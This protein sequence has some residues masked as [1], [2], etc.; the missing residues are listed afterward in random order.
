MYIIQHSFVLHS[1]YV[2][3]TTRQSSH[4]FWHEYKFSRATSFSHGKSALEHYEM[5]YEKWIAVERLVVSVKQR[6]LQ[7]NLKSLYFFSFFSVNILSLFLL[8]VNV[9]KY[10]QDTRKKYGKH[11]FMLT[12]VVVLPVLLVAWD[13]ELI[14][15]WI[16]LWCSKRVRYHDLECSNGRAQSSI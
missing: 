11:K 13:L 4:T 15:R 10:H 6:K 12:F 7:C 3:T 9:R 14:H 5:F 2:Q 8:R 1:S 16:F